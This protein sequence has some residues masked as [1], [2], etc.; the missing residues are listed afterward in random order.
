MLRFSALLGLCLAAL[1]ALVPIRASAKPPSRERPRLA[2]VVLD[3]REGV[4]LDEKQLIAALERVVEVDVELS[5]DHRRSAQLGLL[6]VMLARQQANLLWT[7]PDG[8]SGLARVPMQSSLQQL[9]T[10][11]SSAFESMS[12]RL[13]VAPSA[14]A[15][16][17]RHALVNP[18][19]PLLVAERR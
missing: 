17:V 13:G 19:A 9:L 11:V 7:L 8:R 12:L 18:A 3:R 6:S 10:R 14:S 16:R 4:P 5:S 15:K 2:L 1:F